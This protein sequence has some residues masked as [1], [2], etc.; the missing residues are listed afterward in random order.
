MHDR[1]V[2]SDECQELMVSYYCCLLCRSD[3]DLKRVYYMYAPQHMDCEA[4]VG[5]YSCVT[6]IQRFLPKVKPNCCAATEYLCGEEESE[7]TENCQAYLK[8]GVS[9]A[10]P[11]LLLIA[12]AIR[13]AT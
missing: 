4:L 9:Q 1:S 5:A 8:S 12:A 2:L 7:I 11:F 6:H 3:G 13:L 10:A